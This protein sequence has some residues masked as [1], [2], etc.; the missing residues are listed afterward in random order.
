MLEKNSM[1]DIVYLKEQ[2][3][4]DKS[5]NLLFANCLIWEPA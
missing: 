1:S 3:L 5:L 4:T 2:K